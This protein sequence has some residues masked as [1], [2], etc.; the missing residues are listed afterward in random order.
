MIIYYFNAD[1][2]FSERIKKFING[3]DLSTD[4][5]TNE[6]YK[7][8][9]ET[10][11]YISTISKTTLII[12]FFD[13]R[14]WYNYLNTR[15]YKFSMTGY[16]FNKEFTIDYFND[17]LLFTSTVSPNGGSSLSSMLL[18][19]SYPNGTDFYMNISPYVTDSGY[20]Q[21]GYNLID[22]LLQNIYTIENN[23][24]GYSRIEKVKL[25]EIPDEIKFYRIGNNT[26]LI[27]GEEINSDN[28]LKQNKDLIKYDRNYTLDFQF[29][30]LGL[31]T[32]EDVYK[33]AHEK[34]K[35][36]N[37]GYN[38]FPDNYN[39]TIYYGRV[40]KLTFRLC[41]DFCE[42]CKEI[43]Y[44][45]NDQKC[46]TCLPEYKYDYYNYFNIYSEN[47]V[48]SGYYNDLTNK[49]I[50]A[51]SSTNSKYYYN[52]TDNNKKICFDKSKPCPDTYSFLNTTTNECLNYTPP[53][54]TIPTTIQ[55]KPTTVLLPPTTIPTVPTTIPI[56]PTTIIE[57]IPTT[58]PFVPTTVIKIPTTIP[59]ILTTIPAIPT[60][61][62]KIPTTIIKI[63]T[64]IPFIP[65][66]IPAIPT[67]VPKI[68]TTIVYNIP[69]T[70]LTIQTTILKIQ[71]TI[72]TTIPKIEPII[73]TIPT[74][75]ITNEINIPTTFQR[76]PPTT[77][78]NIITTLPK[79]NTPTTIPTKITEAIHPTIYYDK[80]LNGTYITNLC[81]NITDE[82]LLSRLMMEIFDSYSADKA[83][84]TYRGNNDYSLSISNTLDEM[85]D[86]NRVSFIDLGECETSLKKANHIPLD[87][88]LIIFKK[89][90]NGVDGS[91]MDVQ[92]E[93]YN[94]FNYEK[95]DLSVCE[96][97]TIDLYVPLQLSE[98]LEKI[99][100]NFA[101]Q[102]YN[103]FDLGDKF[104]REIC[105]PY[106]SE[107]G[108]DVLLD[109]REEFFYYPLAEQM[110]CQNNCVFSSYSLDTKYMKC[111]CGINK[112]LVT[113]DLK[114]IS[115]EN[116]FNSFLSTLQSTNYKVMRCYNLVFNF[117]IFCKNVGSILTLIFFIAY[118]VFMIYYCKKQIDP[119]KIKISKILF[120]EQM[121]KNMNDYNQFGIK[122]FEKVKINEKGN[123]SE[124]KT[125]KK[126]VKN[127][128]K[129][130]NSKK[131][132]NN[133]S[134]EIVKTTENSKINATSKTNLKKKTV[135]SQNKSS[136]SHSNKNK[137]KKRNKV[138]FDSNDSSEEVTNIKKRN[139]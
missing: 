28:I 81:S 26:A 130:Q 6:F 103:P 97:T 98:E 24:F 63:P 67:T 71:T 31:K 77:L 45:N 86:N 106:N 121:K 27:S 8:N 13:T 110:V 134:V 7:I 59:L 79:E 133:T 44:S 4:I 100:E 91:D 66:T 99:C 41:H 20:Y 46:I 125:L 127:P 5:T 35:M 114:H 83:A 1:F 73:T 120:N 136:N 76:L 22:Y 3:Y 33:Q 69:T 119:L 50:E 126:K 51:C 101:E 102:G 84:K 124:K 21:N 60:I 89:Q 34:N 138:S 129:R 116:V 39:Q 64:T 29:M 19:F 55:I 49:K 47:C 72:I 70:I 90:K 25:I 61:I 43:G 137:L 112:P 36:S 122:K 74:T 80:C 56:N 17:F 104:Y 57:K 42:T 75:I 93:V 48:P 85:R 18:F 87:S 107:N 105:T 131:I 139:N 9:N 11:L 37:N 40:N 65:T 113:L 88:E 135:I 32:Y 95:L 15:T 12:M 111:E 96:N 92:F 132:T 109:D 16:Y 115:K 38:N 108:T 10:L 62:P 117:K 30:A 52:I 118:M 123:K 82:Q 68:P 58:I 78:P 54:T 53:I 94:P 128:P 14:D 2:S 23:I